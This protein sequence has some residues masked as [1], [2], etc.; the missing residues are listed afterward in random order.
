MGSGLIYAAIIAAWALFFIPRWLRRHEE[1]SEARSVE[2]FDQA[3]RILSGREASP[4]QRRLVA[5]GRP[6]RV[7]DAGEVPARGGSRLAVRRRRVLVGLVLLALV[8]GAVTPFAVL[9][10]WTPAAPLLAVV[11][12]LVHLRLQARRRRDLNRTRTAVRRRTR[13]RLRRLDSAERVVEARRV[14]AVRRAA[15]EAERV[16]T[17]WAAHE[18]ARLDG[19]QAAADAMGWEPTPVPLPT[20]VTK[21]AAPRASRPIDLTRPGRWTEEQ[22]R[23]AAAAPPGDEIFDQTATVP[24]ATVGG[25]GTTSAPAASYDD[26]AAELEEILARRRAVND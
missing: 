9:P 1:L 20:Y 11:V 22:A 5:P 14:L 17:E 4:D 6:E 18:A 7:S 12:D 16:G 8:V 24:A 25:S 15:A 21:P 13:S 2:R 23:Y 26:Y 19:E 3:M 10:W